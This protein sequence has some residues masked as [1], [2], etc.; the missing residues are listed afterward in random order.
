MV[1]TEINAQIQYA[2]QAPKLF[3]Y[4]MEKFG[5]IDTQISALNFTGLGRAKQRLDRARSIRTTKW[6]YGWLNV[7][8]QKRKMGEDGTCPCC[9]LVEEDQLHLFRCTNRRME[10]TFD[11]GIRA[12]QKSLYKDGI[13]TPVV[14]AF[15]NEL[16]RC[17]KKPPIAKTPIHCEETLATV[18]ASQTLGVEAFVRGLHHVDWAYLLRNKW[19]PPA[20][21]PNG[22]KE[23]R[24]DPMEQSVSL[25]R[26]V[27]DIMEAV[28]ECRN[29]ILHGKENQLLSKSEESVTAR[30]LEFRLGNTEMLRRCDRFII[31]KHTVRDVIKWPRERKKAVLDHLETLHKVYVNELRRESEGYRDIRSYFT[32]LDDTSST[33]DDS[34]LGLMLHMPVAEPHTTVSP[35]AM[36]T[37]ALSPSVTA[38]A[39]PLC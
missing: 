30:L 13:S 33:E 10:A 6:I 31:A 25:I 2:A 17:A 14:T 19:I 9:G 23:R 32:R 21:L 26:G 18:E 39:V 11:T 24:K 22:K 36:E 1:T 34:E 20:T 3:T 35:T 4:L 8:A 28:W 16:C 12:L 15:V 27:W 38:P 37:S 5:W 29:D 7:G